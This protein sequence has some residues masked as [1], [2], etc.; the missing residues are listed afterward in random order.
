[1][2]GQGKWAN[3]RY[4]G[5]GPGDTAIVIDCFTDDPERVTAEV[6]HA[7]EAHGGYLGADG[8]V[9]YLFNPVGRIRFAAGA[10]GKKLEAV[11]FAAGAEDVVTHDDGSVEVLTDPIEL[12]W[13][14]T[15]LSQAGFVAENA[16]VTERAAAAA[17]VTGETARCTVRLLDALEEIPDVRNVYSNAAIPS[18]VLAAV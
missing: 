12:E 9:S 2:A 5:Y 6:R 17:P 11:A 3:I 18:E 1:M 15:Q 8:A 13:V 7:F 16:E 4:E 14:R 10:R